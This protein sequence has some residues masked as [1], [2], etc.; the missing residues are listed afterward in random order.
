M[1]Y[2]VIVNLYL[3]PLFRAWALKKIREVLETTKL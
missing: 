3:E 1:H 2:D